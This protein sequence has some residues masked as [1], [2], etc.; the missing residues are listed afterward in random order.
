MLIGQIQCQL[1][2]AD[3]FSSEVST[4]PH[5]EY[6][7]TFH[8]IHV[9]LG[10]HQCV[11]I[12][13]STHNPKNQHG[14]AVD[15]AIDKACPNGFNLSHARYSLDPQSSR[16]VSQTCIESFFRFLAGLVHVTNSSQLNV[17]PV[18]CASELIFSIW[19]CFDLT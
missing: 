5:G 11:I 17:S 8:T 2:E 6:T 9:I 19:N 1:V 13:R 4:Q 7:E 15:A 10:D 14:K 3:F 18:I 12:C 16:C